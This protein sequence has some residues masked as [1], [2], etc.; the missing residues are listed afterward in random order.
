[1]V[2][3]RC[4]GSVGRALA[5]LVRPPLAVLAG[6]SAYLGASTVVAWWA[7]GCGRGRTPRRAEPTTRFAVLVPAHDEEQLIAGALANLTSL[8]YPAQLYRVH[9]V[10]D[11]CTDQTVEIAAGFDVDVHEHV[12]PEARGKGPALQWALQRLWDR[13]DAP[14][15][16]APDVVVFVDADSV[17]DTD[18]L[19][20]LDARF[21]GGAVA[22]QG[23][24]AVA[25]LGDSTAAGLRAAAL[26]V[27]HYLRPLAR[28]TVGASSGLYGNG[29]A[30]TADVLRQRAW[31]D[32]LT[33]DIEFQMELLLA[34]HIVDFAPDAVVAAEMPAT[35]H[36]ATTQNERW[37][38]GRV[39]M[40]KRY[41]PALLRQA[42]RPG[43]RRR[44]ALF[45]GVVDHVLPPF[46]VLVAATIATTGLAGAVRI[47]APARAAQ[48]G[49]RLAVVV[50]VTQ[51]AY[52]LSGLAM[53]KAP[54]SVYRSLLR[55]PSMVAWK[56]G[57][58][59]RTLA[60]REQA[61]WVR[62]V[63]NAEAGGQG[64]DR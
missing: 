45:D 50:C 48:R 40:A 54:A 30:F 31:S 17:L 4:G 7:L 27:R 60:G 24:Y 38:R 8:D 61:T 19:R 56:V 35:L 6:L 51:G 64:D 14:D 11:H 3:V 59:V 46:S 10:A 62:T 47:V 36:G 58:W 44:V 5:A 23:H 20:V 41:V 53:T 26:S 32:H 55:A 1:M 21:A 49:W 2:S 13:A 22:V 37:E 52:L 25:N 63:R 12:R 15:V 29:M 57:L 16:D 39:E 9:L 34:G 33:E 42:V 28:T 43:A 18:F